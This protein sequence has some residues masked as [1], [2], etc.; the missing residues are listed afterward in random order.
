MRRLLV[1]AVALALAIGLAAGEA[2]AQS[3]QP[4]DAN[5]VVPPRLAQDSPAKYP[6]EARRADVLVDL[7]LDVDPTGAVAKAVVEKSGGAGF[8]EAALEAAKGLK[9]EPATRGARPIAARIRFT[10][11][12]TP[13]PAR[14][15]GRIAR[16]ATDSPIAGATVVVKDSAGV[17]HRATTGADGRFRV[18]ALPFGK[19]HLRIS[20]PRQEPVDADEELAPGEEYELTFRL[21]PPPEPKQDDLGGVAGPPPEVEEVRVKGDRPPREVTKR[22]ISR[23]EVFSSP[24]TNGDALR[25]VQNLPGVARPPPFGGQLVVRGSAPQDTQTFIDGTNVPLIYHFG[26][27]SSVVP[28]ESLDRIDFYPGNFGAQYGRGMGGIIDV[29]LR[30]PNADGTFHAMAQLDSIDVRFFVE[31]SLGK[32]WSFSASGRRSYFDVWLGLLAG[33]GLATAPRYYDYQLMVRK[34]FS[35]DH[36]L[37]FTFF[38]SD[39]RL[40]IFNTATNGGDFLLGGNIRA[41]ITFWRAQARYQNKLK[42]GTRITAVAAIG[43]DAID[44]G[45][46]ENYAVI[47]A[48]PVSLRTE[49]SQR[50]VRQLTVNAGIDI[51][52]TPYE[53]TVRFPRPERPGVPSGGIGAPALT[54]VNDGSVYTPGAYGELEIAPLKGTRIVPGFRADYTN[55][56]KEWNYSPRV[57][58]RQEVPHGG[59]RTT[60]KGGVGLFYQPP[61]PFE[62]DPIFGQRGL[63]ANKSVHYS[64]GLEQELLG[65]AELGVEGFYKELDRL[66]VTDAGNGGS[67]FVYGTETLVRWKNDPKMFGWLAYTISRSE[68]RDGPGEALHLA[69]FDQTHILTLLASRVFG[70]GLR[71]GA[72]FR[73][74][75]G[76]LFTANAYNS[77][78]DADRAAYQPVGT[79]PLYNDRMRAFHQLDLRFEKRFDGARPFKAVTAYVDIQNVYYHR[80]QEGVEYNYNYTV[81]RSL[82]GLPQLFITG[83]RMDL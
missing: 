45:F 39:D 50:I 57:V 31:R 76:N 56:T 29:G 1:V 40:E 13:P 23:D 54:A 15:V 44:F 62:L 64:V 59:A 7:I 16:R 11:T 41:A 69:P 47:D 28:S 67:G 30:D 43:Q 42:T 58:A 12:F 78:F 73:F 10:Y 46:G 17:E 53:V 52:H 68:R 77:V 27:L 82:Q 18:D 35:P 25:A 37:R 20:A 65:K 5:A 61:S 70:N 79:L 2:R 49:I 66:V 63:R 14:I 60:L 38:G 51:L 48:M 55:Q 33:D 3:D 74:V 9:F 83:V 8:D 75:S 21:Q 72:R 80:A 4:A 36:D 24:G 71:V 32:G 81:S 22:T 6:A 34:E 19:A 26:G